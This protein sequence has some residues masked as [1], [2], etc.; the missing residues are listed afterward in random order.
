MSNNY[1]R[2]S[3]ML[4]QQKRKMFLLRLLTLLV[5]LIPVGIG[6]IIQSVILLGVGIVCALIMFLGFGLPT[7][8]KI[9][10]LKKQLR[11]SEQM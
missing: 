9:A 11:D 5:V 1:E 4:D 6:A 10:D 3:Q 2:I 8:R 7:M